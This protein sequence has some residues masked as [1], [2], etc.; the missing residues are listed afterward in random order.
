MPA[1]DIGEF[2]IAADDSMALRTPFQPGVYNATSTDATAAIQNAIDDLPTAGGTVRILSGNY[3]LNRASGTDHCITVTSSNIRIV[4]DQG[5]VLKIANDQAKAGESLDM[6]FVDHTS[7]SGFTLWGPGTLNGNKDNNP[8]VGSNLVL[9]NRGLAVEGTAPTDVLVG[10]GITFREMAG[11]C[12][13]IAGPSATPAGDRIRFN[14]ITCRDS[15]EGIQVRHV[16]FVTVNNFH[17]FNM[18]SQDGLELV[19]VVRYAVTNGIIQDTRDECL[20]IPSTSR[21]SSFGVISNVVLGPKVNDDLAQAIV[22]I[23][24]EGGSQAVENLTLSNFVIRMGNARLGIELAGVIGGSTG[25]C[26]GITIAN[27]V[28][29]GALTS[30]LSNPAGIGVGSLATRTLI[31]GVQ[32]NDCNNGASSRAIDLGGTFGGDPDDIQ[33]LNCGGWNN[34][35]GIVA[36]TGA[37]NTLSGNTFQADT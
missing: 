34:V 8:G 17:I 6:I 37:N 27:G 11:V 25:G 31:T 23:G 29:D 36:G 9:N 5:A 4:L 28:I 35:A 14:G 12:V 15:G 21:T 32:I 10:G 7:V 1:A 13:D 18:V 19:S 16:D 33:I 30:A 3:L 22:A 24:G 26:K 20:D 2:I